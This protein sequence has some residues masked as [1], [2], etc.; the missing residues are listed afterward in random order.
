MRDFTSNERQLL[1]DRKQQFEPFLEEMLPVLADF[2]DRIGI[3]N[4]HLIAADPDVFLPPI[5]EFMREQM[6]APNDRS[7]IVTRLGYFIGEVLNKR[8]GGCWFINEWPE[9]RYFLHYVVGQFDDGSRPNAMVDPFEIANAFVAAPPGRDLSK[10]I[11]EVE[12]ACRT[13]PRK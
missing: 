10:L 2:A 3:E 9:T 4:S 5:A 8:L 1:S 7:W 13:H 11:A 6:V 12:S